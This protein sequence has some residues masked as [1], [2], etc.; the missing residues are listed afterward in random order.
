MRL[1]F[2]SNY[3]PHALL[4]LSIQDDGDDDDGLNGRHVVVNVKI[5]FYRTDYTLKA[6]SSNQLHSTHLCY[7]ILVEKTVKAVKEM[8]S[9]E[10]EMD[11]GLE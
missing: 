4:F 9:G 11:M 5:Q 8:R 2:I 6:P 3:I 10:R 1:I 7:V